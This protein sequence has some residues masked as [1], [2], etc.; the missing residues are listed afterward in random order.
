MLGIIAHLKFEVKSV[1]IV[2]CCPCFCFSLGFAV[3]EDDKE[4]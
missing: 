1:T 3:N 4:M 2:V